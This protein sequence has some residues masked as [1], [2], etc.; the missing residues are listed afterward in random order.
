MSPVQL[1][2]FAAAPRKALPS[3]KPRDEH[4]RI[5]ELKCQCGRVLTDAQPC[6]LPAGKCCPDLVRP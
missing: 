6:P 3:E 5:I 1:D 4:F 2:L